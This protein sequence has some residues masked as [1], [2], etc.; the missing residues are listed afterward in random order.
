MA[1]VQVKSIHMDFEN[2]LISAFHSSFPGVDIS[3][4]KFNW[5]NCLLKRIATEGLIVFYNS[6]IRIWSSW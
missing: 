4:C 6:N 2:G 1:Y 3:S 5:K